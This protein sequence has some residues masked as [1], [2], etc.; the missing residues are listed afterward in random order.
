M[1]YWRPSRPRCPSS[2]ASEYA[3]SPVRALHLQFYC[4][5]SAL[6]ANVPVVQGG[7]P[8]S[9][10]CAYKGGGVCLATRDSQGSWLTPATGACGR[11]H[12]SSCL[13]PHGAAPGCMLGP[14]LT[15]VT[16]GWMPHHPSVVDTLFA[17]RSAL[18]SVRPQPLR[19]PCHAPPAAS[20]S[21][22]CLTW[23]WRP[24]STPT[25]GARWHFFCANCLWW[26]SVYL[27]PRPWWDAR[28]PGLA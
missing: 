15:D 1:V 14:L 28:G 20:S 22:T 11:S 19:S 13:R 23:T 12:P 6:I 4:A 3:P 27:P 18:S 17:L 8:F 2:R 9:E 5:C 25:S 16:C 21:S 24:S 7:L 10:V 26:E